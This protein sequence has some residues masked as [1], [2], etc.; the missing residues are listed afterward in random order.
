[1]SN[2]APLETTEIPKYCLGTFDIQ[3]KTTL[4]DKIAKG[5]VIESVFVFHS[6]YSGYP[7]GIVPKTQEREKTEGRCHALE[8]LE[9]LI[10]S[11]S[12]EWVAF[13]LGFPRLV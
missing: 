1:M 5:I 6:C 4:K 10:D 9:H 2:F 7:D 11:L 3:L 13:H 12:I 8:V